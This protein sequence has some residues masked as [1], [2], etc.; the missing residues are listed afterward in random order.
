MEKS[1]NFAANEPSTTPD[2]RF[3][4]SYARKLDFSLLCPN[5]EIQPQVPKNGIF[6]KNSFFWKGLKISLP[7]SPQPP[8]DIKF[9]SSYARK[10]DYAQIWKFSPM[11]P[12]MEFFKKIHFFEKVS[13]FRFQ[14]ALNHP[15][16]LSLSQV[17]QE[18]VI[19]AYYAQ[20]WKFG[21]RIPKMEFF[22]KISFFWKG[23]QIL[24]LTSLKPPADIKFKTSY[25]RKHIIKKVESRTQL[26]NLSGGVAMS[27]NWFLRPKKIFLDLKECFLDQKM[28][29]S[30]FRPKN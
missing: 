14:R 25:A 16:K 8:P 9:K 12:K 6:Q 28:F 30:I 11:F 13:R 24:L 26:F 21:P 17:M 3:K 18:N 10:R 22:K 5:M 20:I 2:I 4:S 29:F 23:L 19:L 7:T 27:K 15:Q 1:L